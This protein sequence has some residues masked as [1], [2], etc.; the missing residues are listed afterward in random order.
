MAMGRATVL[1]R[2]EKRQGVS[3]SVKMANPTMTLTG[4]AGG[5]ANAHS[6]PGNSLRRRGDSGCEPHGDVR[7]EAAHQEPLP[8]PFKER[9]LA[10]GEHAESGT[11]PHCGRK[12]GGKERLSNGLMQSMM[13][14]RK[15]A[16]QELENRR[17][18]EHLRGRAF[19]PCRAARGRSPVR[20]AA[21]VEH[22][23]V[24]VAF[25]G[26]P[27]EKFCPEVKEK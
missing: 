25:R 9:S 26:W 15:E 16:E 4:G 10:S 13:R 18:G 12:G 1:L 27:S 8:L 6:G 7:G 23:P 14:R 2:K 22:A 24:G 19:F 5:M 3:S 20:A 21:Q 11:G 17:Q